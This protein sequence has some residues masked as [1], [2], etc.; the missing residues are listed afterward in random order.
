M[1]IKIFNDTDTA[2][3][4]F[5]DKPVKETKAVSENLYIDLDASGNP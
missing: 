3:V 5:T 1:R 2:L 4:E